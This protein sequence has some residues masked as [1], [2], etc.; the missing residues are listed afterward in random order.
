MGP[1]GVIQFSSSHGGPIILRPCFRRDAHQLAAIVQG[2]NGGQ[3][4][5]LSIE[6]QP[7][8]CPLGQRIRF[9]GT[10]ITAHK[11]LRPE[12]LLSLHGIAAAK[13]IQHVPIDNRVK[14]VRSLLWSGNKALPIQGAEPLAM[15]RVS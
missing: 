3:Q 14:E 13:E 4:H 9:A 11:P 8:V 10:Q 1:G 2:R 15:Q 12:G 7:R 6:A 5:T